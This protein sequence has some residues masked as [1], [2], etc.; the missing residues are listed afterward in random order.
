MTISAEVA[1]AQNAI[2]QLQAPVAVAYAASITL[3]R[4]PVQRIIVTGALTLLPP[5]VGVDGQKVTAWLNASGADRAVT[6][7]ASII[8]SSDSSVTSPFTVVSG[9]KA[10]LELQ[11]DAT[12]AEWELVSLVNGYA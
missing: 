11:Y 6:L 8:I 12:L 5:A 9:T 3:P 7:D 10:V 2:R 4:Y 1:A